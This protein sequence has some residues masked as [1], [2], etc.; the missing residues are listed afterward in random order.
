MT[1]LTI[2]GEVVWGC[3]NS[4]GTFCQQH[5]PRRKQ[6]PLQVLD[7]RSVWRKLH[8]ITA[9]PISVLYRHFVLASFAF[10][11]F[12]PWSF[13]AAH[14][15]PPPA[16]PKTVLLS[17]HSPSLHSTTPCP[18]PVHSSIVDATNHSQAINQPS[19]PCPRG[20]SSKR[21]R[22]RRDTFGKESRLRKLAGTRGAKL[23][24]RNV[25]CR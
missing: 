12:S 16:F 14:P 9:P 2:C 10:R 24:L 23:L 19:T 1:Y 5:V 17:V 13:G 21:Q 22:R 15:L 11:S 8:A 6:L 18:P 20:L 3:C 4:C 7:K 25:S